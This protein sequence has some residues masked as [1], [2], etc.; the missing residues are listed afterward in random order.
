MI[1]YTLTG[2]CVYVLGMS[3]WFGSQ[4]YRNQDQ[5]LP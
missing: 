3:T 2:L 1:A 4:R 5:S